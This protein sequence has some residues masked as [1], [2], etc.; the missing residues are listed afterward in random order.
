MTSVSPGKQYTISAKVI[1]T[2]TVSIDKLQLQFGFYDSSGNG[3]YYK[4][5]FS[6]PADGKV[7][8]LSYTY[9]APANATS[10]RYFCLDYA[11]SANVSHTFTVYDMKTEQ[12]STATPWMPLSSEATTADYPK[13]VGFS[14]IIKPNKTSS[15]YKWLPMGLVSIN[16]AT[17]LLKPAVIGIDYAQAH[18]IGSVVSNN[19]N[20]SSGYM[21]GTWENIG[22]A[23]IGSTTIY[24]WKRTA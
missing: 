23:V 7:Y 14:N 2:G 19:S 11:T 1:N 16:S 10:M 4:E 22:S 15:D 6:I 21:T 8:V 5:N 24:Y 17:G 9:T 12:G 13:Y 20:S 18:P 3:Q